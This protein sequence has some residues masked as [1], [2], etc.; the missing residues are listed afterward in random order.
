M[1]GSNASWICPLPEGQEEVNAS[2]MARLGKKMLELDGEAR[3]LG[4]LGRCSFFF[5]SQIESS[6]IYSE[7]CW[8]AEGNKH[9]GMLRG[10][11]TYST[12]PSVARIC[13]LAR[14]KA[15]SSRGSCHGK[16]HA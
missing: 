16:S 10:I 2:R 9:L 15:L 8:L 11:L 7:A 6:M 1:G 3:G 4:L 5:C 12:D 14:S 13:E